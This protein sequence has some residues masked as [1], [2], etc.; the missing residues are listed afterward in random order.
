MGQEASGLESR[1]LEHIET[2]KKP[3][4][5]GPFFGRF[6][7]EQRLRADTMTYDRNLFRPY[8]DGPRL[9]GMVVATD[10]VSSSALKRYMWGIMG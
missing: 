6:R 2:L 9:T 3:T 10:F 5:K 7:T 4:H 8:W 1:G